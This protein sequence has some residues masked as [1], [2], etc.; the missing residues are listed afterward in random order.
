MPI[1]IHFVISEWWQGYIW[2]TIMYF[3]IV[4]AIKY[5]LQWLRDRSEQAIDPFERR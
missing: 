2:A 1:D 5:F 4:P 3:G